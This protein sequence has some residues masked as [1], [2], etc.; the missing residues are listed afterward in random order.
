VTRSTASPPL[1]RRL[2]HRPASEESIFSL[3]SSGPSS[4][5]ADLPSPV[6]P[7][8]KEQ[9]Q[10]GGTEFGVFDPE[11]VAAV[12]DEVERALPEAVVRLSDLGDGENSVMLASDDKHQ[13]I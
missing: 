3:S 9:A 1:P 4:A 6:G 7:S 8:A 2:A 11:Q 10:G 5:S 13:H 12:R